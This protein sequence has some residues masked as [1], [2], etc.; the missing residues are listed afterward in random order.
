MYPICF[1]QYSMDRTHYALPA[2]FGL[3]PCQSMPRIFLG[4]T[5][6]RSSAI[7]FWRAQV[8]SVPHPSSPHPKI[9]DRVIPPLLYNQR[10]RSH[11]R[12]PASSSALSLSSS[13]CTI[14]INVIYVAHGKMLRMYF[15]VWY[16]IKCISL[17]LYY[18]VTTLCIVCILYMRGPQSPI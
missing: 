3:T 1:R 17:F 12:F 15:H 6:V 18:N 2:A 13:I 5:Y 9:S 10:I 7:K 11:P 16:C 8:S 14:N 4:G